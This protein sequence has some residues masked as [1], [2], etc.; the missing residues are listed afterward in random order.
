MKSFDCIG[1]LVVKLA[2]AI[3]W[4]VSASPGF[5]SRPMHFAVVAEPLLLLV[6]VW[7]RWMV[8]KFAGNV[9]H[10]SARPA[11]YCGSRHLL[12]HHQ[13]CIVLFAFLTCP[14]LYN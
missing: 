11:K 13:T 8:L 7:Y 3:H 14:L 2:V 6:L 10:V 4:T 1:G 5:D 12:E 9:G